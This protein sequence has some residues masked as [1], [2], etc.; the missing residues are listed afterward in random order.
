MINDGPSRI[1]WLGLAVQ[2]LAN[3][4]VARR[5]NDMEY[6]NRLK[7]I[8]KYVR[9]NTAKTM[10]SM[11]SWQIYFEQNQNL[12]NIA[13]IYAKVKTEMGRSAIWTSRN[14]D[15]MSSSVLL[16]IGGFAY[17][18]DSEMHCRGRQH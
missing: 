3:K 5:T 11:V 13:Q 9:E 2:S 8:I 14:L 6:S 12:E 16:N 18:S 10:N 4:E 15:S 17:G 1:T 7:N